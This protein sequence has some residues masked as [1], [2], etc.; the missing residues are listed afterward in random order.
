MITRLWLNNLLG[1]LR[2]YRRLRGG[3][4]ELWKL[5][6]AQGYA[7][8]AVNTCFYVRAMSPD[9]QLFGRP[10]T[11]EHI[12]PS[13]KHHWYFSDMS[14]QS[15]DMPCPICRKQFSNHPIDAYATKKNG[16]P[17]HRTCMG[18]LIGVRKPLM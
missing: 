11:C 1:Q 17:F 4:W 10:R 9:P 12:W 16:L 14:E 8:L 7:W 5:P 2:W 13:A 3:H 6:D 15:V 18:V